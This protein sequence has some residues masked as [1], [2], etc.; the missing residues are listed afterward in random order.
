[1]SPVGP[2]RIE[3]LRRRHVPAVARLEKLVSTNPWSAELFRGELALPEATRAYRVARIGGRLVGYGGLMFVVDEAHVTTLSVHPDRQGERIGT[4]L[5]AVLVR[6]ALRRGTKAL[7]LEVRAGNEPAK[8]L[9]QRF[10]FAPAGIRKNYYAEVGEDAL[11]MWAHDI[12]GDE[13]AARLD[14]IE[15]DLPP[16]EVRA[17]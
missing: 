1:M 12:D 7:T 3:P 10:G 2:L 8:A 11:I 5:L 15:A 9:Y 17:A 14:A 16:A 4:R 13:Y 6:E